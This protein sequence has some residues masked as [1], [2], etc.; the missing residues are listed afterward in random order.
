MDI[1]SHHVV[2]ILADEG[3]KEQV[4]DKVYYVK[5]LGLEVLRSEQGRTCSRLGHKR[6]EKIDGILLPSPENVQNW[7][8]GSEYLPNTTSSDLV[9]Y[10]T[11]SDGIRVLKKGKSLLTS[12]YVS[13]V[14]YMYNGIWNGVSF[15]HVRGEVVP[16]IRINEPP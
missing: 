5:Q 9:D 6:K 10:F 15:S 2:V 11:A 13:I 8:E 3:R 14:E 7:L 16:Q 4:I 1:S 12:G